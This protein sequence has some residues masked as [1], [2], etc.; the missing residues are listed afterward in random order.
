MFDKIYEIT[1]EFFAYALIAFGYCYAI[2]QM[3]AL[4]I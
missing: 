3:T 2:Y 1:A 4:P